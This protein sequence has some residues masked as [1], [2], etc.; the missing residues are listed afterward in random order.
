MDFDI[1]ALT[2]KELKQAI[3]KYGKRAM[4]RLRTLEK[5]YN[6]PKGT[7]YG[8]K[9]YILDRFGDYNTVVK[10][11]SRAALELNLNKAMTILE[12]R[13]STIKGMQEIDKERLETFKKNHPNIGRRN[14][15]EVVDEATWKRAM[16]IMGKIHAAERGTKYDSDEQ[17]FTS[18]KLSKEETS[19]DLDDFVNKRLKEIG[20]SSEYFAKA[21]LDD[22]LDFQRVTDAK[23]TVT[24]EG[25]V[26]T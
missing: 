20:S 22:V 11:K 15:E 3:H 26:A 19:L 4:S 16:S 1:S 9:S 17:L 10:G 2:I 21:D 12:A 6:T 24:E 18:Y 8:R 25:G 5:A 13:S 7:F 23:K 14:P